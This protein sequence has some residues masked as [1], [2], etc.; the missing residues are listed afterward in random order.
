MWILKF[1]V[2]VSL[3]F[4]FVLPS[5]AYAYLDPVTGSFVLQ[6]LIAGFLGA[7]LYL[8]LAWAKVKMF[9]ANLFSKS[10]IQ[11]KTHEVFKK[12]KPSQE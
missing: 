3:T 5:Y 12:E 4:C 1:A 2:P 8:R 9:F 7:L 6:M 10:D 11:T